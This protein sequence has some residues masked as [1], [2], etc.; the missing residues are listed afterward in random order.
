MNYEGWSPPI[1]CFKFHYEE[2]AISGS[3]IRTEIRPTEQKLRS[4][5]WNWTNRT[6]STNLTLFWR[7]HSAWYKYVPEPFNWS[8]LQLWG[9]VVLHEVLSKK[10][11][12]SAW[13]CF[14][15]HK[16]WQNIARNIFFFSSSFEHTPYFVKDLYGR[17]SRK[18]RQK[19]SLRLLL[20]YSRSVRAIFLQNF[21]I[22]NLCGNRK[23]YF[24]FNL[25]A[26]VGNYVENTISNGT[27][28]K[29]QPTLNGK[30]CRLNL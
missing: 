12:F 26:H 29:V 18:I 10:N 4:Q 16:K 30:E 1:F 22:K 8:A 27:F 11:V 15:F 5:I 17:I 21:R 7:S 25:R 28:S 24:L 20:S 23:L 13:I 2:P 19:V 9:A 6:E 3:I 14:L